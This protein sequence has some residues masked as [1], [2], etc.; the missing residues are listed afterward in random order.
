MYE[1]CLVRGS[2]VPRKDLEDMEARFREMRDKKT[3]LQKDLDSKTKL[4]KDSRNES[5]SLEARLRMASDKLAKTSQDLEAQRLTSKTLQGQLDESE[6]QLRAK[7]K[8]YKELSESL[9][10]A[11]SGRKDM[12]LALQKTIGENAYVEVQ[13]EAAAQ[14]IECEDKKR[15]LAAVHEENEQ[16]HKTNRQ[17]AA[18]IV[19]GSWRRMNVQTVPMIK[20]HKV[21]EDASDA[22]QTLSLEKTQ[23]EAL[24]S[25]CATLQLKVHELNNEIAELKSASEGSTSKSELL[26][27]N[28]ELERMREEL[29]AKDKEL[30]NGAEIS[31]SAAQ[32]LRAAEAA[33][34][35]V[36][37]R[38]VARDEHVKTRGKLTDCQAA[39][40]GKSTA[41]AEQRDLYAQLQRRFQQLQESYD[42]ANAA[43][44]LRGDLN[45]AHAKIKAL[46]Q[47]NTML[48]TELR[49]ERLKHA[50]FLKGL[51]STNDL[52][53]FKG[54]IEQLKARLEKSA[55]KEHLVKAK[56]SV[57][58]LQDENV[59]LKTQNGS[60]RNLL[61]SQGQI[62]KNQLKEMEE[63]VLEAS[64]MVPES[65]AAR[66]KVQVMQLEDEIASLRQEKDECKKHVAD[67]QTREADLRAEVGALEAK[68]ND[69]VQRE[70]WEEAGLEARQLKGEAENLRAEVG[71]MERQAKSLQTLL[72]DMVPGADLEEART[73][74]EKTESEVRQLK[75]LLAQ[76][77]LSDHDSLA[78]F[79]E[80]VVGPPHHDMAQLIGLLHVIR[81]SKECGLEAMARFISNLDDMSLTLEQAVRLLQALRG[82]PVRSVHD[83]CI[84]I[85]ALNGTDEESA[86]EGTEMMR[87]LRVMRQHP[88]LRVSELSRMLEHCNS[89]QELQRLYDS[90]CTDPEAHGRDQRSKGGIGLL[91]EQVSKKE[92]GGTT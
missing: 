38:S 90:M 30:L 65:E 40:E 10:R 50:E 19:Q 74:L 21:L 35:E 11:E 49:Q 51:Q 69:L 66:L 18:R 92:G 91:L 78:R 9:A 32:K 28:Q 86:W 24:E 75:R 45:D 67:G 57:K 6:V 36:K 17:L 88:Q 84:V 43:A 52:R 7:A 59:F 53:S 54:Q 16:L 2:M 20:H 34:E 77:G 5:E 58:V 44:G 56:R 82:P 4:A 14:R 1:R 64:T 25:R 27:A 76:A 63:F 61:V 3:A 89:L 15:E 55:P 31:A 62:V 73:A 60:M 46:D 13:N 72:A 81:A 87:L 8:T 85:Q 26:A 37:N 33:L 71:A 80:A 39:L 70:L 47:R 41:L 79:L 29:S 12:E 68:M 48:D 83:I 23:R 42:T 22:K